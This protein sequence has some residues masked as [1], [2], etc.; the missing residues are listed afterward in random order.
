MCVRLTLIAIAVIGTLSSP[1]LNAQYYYLEGV[2][3]PLTIDST[4]CLL[5]FSP[6]FTGEKADLVLDLYPEIIDMLA[7][8]YTLDTFV[9]CT[10]QDVE[11]YH[12]F[13][14]DIAESQHFDFAEPYYVIDDST[15]F[16]VGMTICCQFAEDAA[17]NQIDSLLE[18]YHL[19]I[20]HEV[21]LSKSY[22]LALT[23]ESPGNALEVANAL[24]E[25]GLTRYA[26]PNLRPHL[27][28]DGYRAYDFFIPEQWNII[29]IIGN[30]DSTS[31]WDITTGDTSVIVAVLDEGYD[32]H[33]EIPEERMVMGWDFGDLDS[34]PTPW[35]SS[36]HGYACAG[37]IMAN[38]TI[39]SN[40]QGYI[41]TGIVSM[42]P[43]VKQMPL[44]I[45]MNSTQQGYHMPSST[46][47]IGDAFRF[48][49]E[50]GADVISCSWH[51]LR[52]G[53]PFGP[54]K[55]AM[56]EAIQYG[57][58]GKGCV[59][60]C[61]SGSQGYSTIN[62]PASDTAALAVGAIDE[63]D[64]IWSFSNYGE[65]LDVVAPS[66]DGGWYTG[67]YTLDQMDELGLNDAC[68]YSTDDYICSFSGT[69]AACPLVSG[70]AA[71]LISRRSD[72]TYRE[73]FDVVRYSAKTELQWGTITPP[74]TLYGYGKADAWR[75]LLAVCRGDA[76]NNH[77]INILD[78]TYIIAF[79]YK[80]GPPP[81]PEL[82]MGDAKCDGVVN[83][84]DVNYLIQYLWY[85]GPKPEICFEY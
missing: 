26:E 68:Q 13:L 28:T 75:A 82:L 19:A 22:L 25:S 76:N 66:G 44:K 49:Y 52:K 80:G 61:A 74:D 23:Q 33:E 14:S 55:T 15:P 77:V 54:V 37:L 3:T 69:S 2:Q 64:S 30:Y 70:I 71:L 47:N 62:F 41:I 65:S 21:S 18:H 31:A 59:I 43:N 46:Y 36:V 39:D 45:F 56:A 57:R 63:Q 73:V 50:H 8:P 78:V 40:Y 16:V 48:A 10:L 9:L 34:D 42:A 53:W 29:N 11:D 17:S 20:A 51:L 81:T 72:L 85:S 12:Q 67:I 58:G 6:E 5:R 79:I 4:K 35:D 60:V 32:W 7:S 24:F 83:I 38:H 1:Q 27:F 84:L